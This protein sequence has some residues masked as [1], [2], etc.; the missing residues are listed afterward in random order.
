MA[1]TIGH[2]S[3]DESRRAS[4][5]SAGDQTGGEVCTRNWY[6]SP[7]NF[8][9]RCK[10]RAKAKKMVKAMKAACANKNIG[11][12][13]YQRNTLLP[14]AKACGWDLSK[15]TTPCE[16]DCS[17]LVTVCAQAAGIDVPYVYGNAPYTGN[18]QAQFTKTG[19]FEVLTASKYLTSDAFLLEGD[20]LVKTSGHTAMALENG[21]QANDKATSVEKKTVAEI[22]EEVIAGKWGIGATRKARLTAAGY[23]YS[24]VQAAVNAKLTGK[25]SVEEIAK[26]VIAGKWGVGAQRVAKLKAAGYDPAKVQA[27][28]NQLLK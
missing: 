28:V 9:L 25:K 21:A 14:Q 12:D 15:I 26:E 3:A 17:S 22:A 20:I 16:C 11:Y 5:G 1:I 6:S 8:V 4:G 27:K 7:W 19:E 13:Q 2:A 10:D 23:N 24:E 18:M